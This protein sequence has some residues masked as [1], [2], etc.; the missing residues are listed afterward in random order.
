M[1]GWCLD[2]ESNDTPQ[3]KFPVNCD[4]KV[5]GL[6]AVQAHWLAQR[7]FFL[8]TLLSCPPPSMLTVWTWRGRGSTAG[9]TCCRNAPIS[10]MTKKLEAV[11]G[12]GETSSLLRDPG[13]RQPRTPASYLLE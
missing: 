6:V 9:L 2:R 10:Q 7:I 8:L 13:T 5:P 4:S 1:Q 12:A 3:R 11:K